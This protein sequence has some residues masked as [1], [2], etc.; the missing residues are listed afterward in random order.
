MG[1][2]KLAVMV[3]VAA[4]SLQGFAQSDSAGLR[5]H[6]LKMYNQ[7]L[8][9]NDLETAIHSLHGLIAV[10]NNLA[11]KDTLSMLYFTHKSYYS[12][13]LLAEEVYKTNPGNL[14]AMARAGECYDEL[15]D[16][17]TAISLFE[18][19]SPKTKNPYHYYKLAISQYQLKRMAESEAT[20]KMVIADTNSAKVGVNFEMGDG[21]SQLVPVNAAASNLMGV[22]QLEAKNYETAKSHFKQ[23][24]NY[25][26]QFAGAQQNLK[27]S[28][29]NA[30]KSAKPPVKNVVNKPKN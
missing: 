7:A 15:G 3:F 12:S 2:K 11:Y 30:K 17:K 9:Y 19:V 18:Q 14:A 1:M 20:A 5:R 16:P 24:L 8:A 6:Y 29:E 26:P 27:V 21:S 23:A 28:E 25:F 4:V 10:D 13:L 22:I